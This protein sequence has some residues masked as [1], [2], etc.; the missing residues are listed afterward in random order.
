M[1]T[2]SDSERELLVSL[3]DF[4]LELD[5]IENTLVNNE[6]P[7]DKYQG[8][9]VLYMNEDGQFYLKFFNDEYLSQS[10]TVK[11]LFAEPKKY[12]IYSMEGADYNGKEYSCNYLSIGFPILNVAHFKLQGKI[13]GS[14]SMSLSSKIIF[15]GEYSLPMDKI[16]TTKTSFG[17]NLY[18]TDYK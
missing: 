13:R 9:G 15:A 3:V 4:S 6:N 2:S 7:D 5:L 17:D 14:H 10:Q 1:D 16:S 18:Y 8:K 11:R 12:P